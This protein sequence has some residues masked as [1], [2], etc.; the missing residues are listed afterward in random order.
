MTDH[1]DLPMTT[2]AASAYCSERGFPAAEA[3]LMKFRRMGGGPAFLRFGRRVLYRPS[4]L[5]RWIEQRTRET[6]P[7]IAAA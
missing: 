5:E 3:T 4:A 2:R 6:L 7:T 1:D